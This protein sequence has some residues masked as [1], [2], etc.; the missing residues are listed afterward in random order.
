MAERSKAP[1][2]SSGSRK[3]AWVSS[4]QDGRAVEDLSSGSRKSVGV[5]MAERSKAPDLSS[6]S[7]KRAWNDSLRIFFV[8]G[9]LIFKLWFSKSKGIRKDL[10][11][12]VV[13]SNHKVSF[14]LT[15]VF[16]SGVRMAERSKAPDLSSGSRKRAWE[17]GWPSSKESGGWLRNWV[18]TPLPTIAG[19]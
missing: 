13:G 9:S 1:D 2:L 5:R 17:S 3:R 16:G 12:V 19:R 4:S 8:V 10:L 7:R 14:H 15:R 11:T 18:R 6:G